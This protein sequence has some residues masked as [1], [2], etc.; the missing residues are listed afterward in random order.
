MRVE[1]EVIISERL[2]VL[3]LAG[4]R[5]QSSWLSLFQGHTTHEALSLCLSRLSSA[6]GGINIYFRIWLFLLPIPTTTNW[7]V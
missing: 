5:S 6:S 7:R 1:Q 2:A 3:Y 4:T